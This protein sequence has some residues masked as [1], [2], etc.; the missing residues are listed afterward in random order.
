[1]VAREVYDEIGGL[2]PLYQTHQFDDNDFCLRAALFG[3]D[4]YIEPTALIAHLYKRSFAANI[5]HADIRCNYMIFVYLN[6]G[7][8]KFEE[9]KTMEEGEYGYAEGLALFESLRP[10]VEEF[11]RWIAAH[12]RRSTEELLARLPPGEPQFA[13]AVH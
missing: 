12:Q 13:S 8:E 5:T 4:C 2:C 3:Y 11:R 10:Q 9:L 6:L 7:P 1:M